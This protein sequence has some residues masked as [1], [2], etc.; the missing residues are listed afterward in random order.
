MKSCPEGRAQRVHDQKQGDQLPGDGGWGFRMGR[1]DPESS[2]V[3]S[4]EPRLKASPF[5]SV[6]F[7][8]PRCGVRPAGQ[9]MMATEET[10][11]YS[12]FPREGGTPRPG[13]LTRTHQPVRR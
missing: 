7:V 10:G 9:E 13:G 6:G 8:L 1:F 12:R 4:S 5:G 2:S 11:C 3:A